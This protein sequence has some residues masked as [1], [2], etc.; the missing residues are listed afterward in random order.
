MDVFTAL[1]GKLENLV[2]QRFERP[3]EIQ[4]ES[5]P[6]ALEGKNLLLISE[7]G[8]GKTE[9][10]LLPVFSQFLKK[11]HNPISIL[12]ITPLKSLNRDLLKRIL[13]W[14]KKLD[15]DVSVRHGD[16]TQY[17]RSMQ[18]ANPS[19][20]LISTPETLQSIMVGKVMRKHLR[21]VKWVVIDEI[22][23]L[24]D[25]KRGA[26]L[27]IGLERLKRLAGDFQVIGLSA[28]VGSPEKVASFLGKGFRI[29]DA[30]REKKISLSVDS[31]GTGPEDVLLSKKLL[32]SPETAA[33]VR[34]IRD[35]VRKKESVL[36]FTNTRESAEVISSRLKVIDPGLPLETHHS[37][38]SKEVRISA[39]KDFKE[40]R[41]KALLC[42]SSLELGI[43]IGA[44]DFVLQFLSPRQVMKALQR[45]GRSGHSISRVSEGLIVGGDSDD[46]FESAAIA[47]N[48]AKRK[49]EKTS[50]YEKALDV[51]GHQLTGL[52]LEDYE[53]PLDQAYSLVKKAW[54]F[55]KLSEAEFFEV[56]V[57]MER[58]GVLWINYKDGGFVEMYKSG[59][60]KRED[61]F[62]GKALK[63]LV[64]KRRRNA[65][66]YYFQNLSTIPDVRKF[67]VHDV[68]SNRPVGTLDAEFIALHGSPGQGVI[69]K[70]QAWRILDIG[71][72][73]VMVE[74]MSGIEAAVPAW[75]GELI[76][77]PFEIAQKVGSIRRE[78]A[79]LLEKKKDPVPFLAEKYPITKRVAKKLVNAVK[80][81]SAWGTLP[82]DRKVLVE[83]DNE[84]IIF[85]TCWG[86]LVNDT[87]GRVLSVLLT[88]RLGSVGL[89]I[90]PY[91]IVLKTSGFAW[92]E[93]AELFMDLNPKRVETVLKDSLP[94]TEL[95]HWRFLH[96]AKRLGIIE[97]NAEFGKGYLRKIIEAYSN[98]PVYQ[99]ALNEIYQDKLD[100][101]KTREVLKLVREK[102]IKIT[103]KEGVSPLGK[104]ALA[105]RYEIVPPERPEKEIFEIFKKRLLETKI[106][107]V[108]C[109]C[110]KWVSIF[111]VRDI[112][113][114]IK[115]EKCSA[116]LISVVP[117]RYLIEAQEIILKKLQKKKLSKEEERW[118]SMATDTASIVLAHGREAALTLAGRGVGLKTS[119][120]I[121]AKMQTGDELIREILHAERNY[122]KT[123]RFWK[124]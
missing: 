119:G 24:V 38:L 48:A 18:A 84:N 62:K 56:C 78:V 79:D 85:H 107:L 69:V 2:R 103:I 92:R 70:G 44:I 47:G 50:V 23:E 108:C 53:I 30:A 123:R 32:L 77:V 110:G 54:P 111:R 20:M 109:N 121:L 31:P 17:E 100:L 105:R 11:E 58:L 7:T 52:V 90:D 60:I 42:T 115:C 55:R 19:D 4:K 106:G 8:S 104:G 21:N 5:I 57:L 97:R 118:L 46:C 22:H 65:W 51:L 101:E 61:R 49:I 87:I 16:T 3:T 35:I 94:N 25:N 27:S 80:E 72:S 122:V 39:E 82:T 102:K 15:F 117:K 40:Q 12:Y 86:S 99:E 34:K 91:R 29:I 88:E 74:P 96:V 6:L 98:S 73:R 71:E 28:T 89:K 63:D 113:E 81:Q 95:F 45:V 37:S 43:D 10:I 64:L 1:G 68:F 76:P 66:T 120:R 116:R 59:K 83:Y 14:S 124:D 36:V 13:W 9:S 112:P 75:V 93:A 26:Q 67:K 114:N 41:L 33:R